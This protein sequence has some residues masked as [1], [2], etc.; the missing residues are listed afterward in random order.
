VAISAVQVVALVE[1][2]AKVATEATAVVPQAGRAAW[3]GLRPGRNPG[4]RGL[5]D[6]PNLGTLGHWLRRRI[7]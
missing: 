2:R 5:P 3:R 4:H 7:A 1:D 6:G